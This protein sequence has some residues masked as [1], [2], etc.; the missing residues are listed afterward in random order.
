MTFEE[1]KSWAELLYYFSGILLLVGLVFGYIQLRVVKR[2]IDDR[3]KRLA[4]EKSLEHLQFY[5]SSIIPETDKIKMKFKDEIE[6]RI[7]TSHL[8]NGKFDVSLDM[9]T[10]EETDE[11]KQIMIECL[12]N[13]DLKLH[14]VMN[15]LEFFSAGV[16][17]GIADENLVYT[18]VA[19]HF[20]R[21]IEREHIFLSL[22]KSRGAPY[23]N[24]IDLYFKWK[25]KI[26][27]EEDELQIE[28]AS[29][30]I[31]EKVARRKTTNVGM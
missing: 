19:R 1:F 15:Q 9:F 21:L 6:N 10:K 16:L 14:N 27:I 4:A 25:D 13:Q 28:R 7:D 17:N 2:D 20:C 29:A 8:F 24:L 23:K 5:A 12:L 31:R 18:P 30:R 26:D 22:L 11:N 3:N